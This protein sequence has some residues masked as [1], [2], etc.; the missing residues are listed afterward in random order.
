MTS[1]SLNVCLVSEEFPPDSGWGGIGTYTYN[2]ALGLSALGHRVRVISRGWG[3]DTV[4]DVNGVPVYRLSVAEPSW[5]RGTRFLSTRFYET[6]QILLWNVRVARLLRR[7]RAAEPIDLIECPE[8]HAQGV[9]AS[10][11]VTRVPVVVKLHTP[12]WLCR[13]VNGV[14]AGGSTLDTRIGEGLEYRLARRAGMLTSPSLKLAE[15][16]AKRWGLPVDA[17]RVIPNPI[18]DEL[19]QTRADVARDASRV[20]YV[21]RV[22][23]RKGVTTLADA[24]PTVRASFPETSL[25]LV[26]RD[27]PSGRDGSSMTKHLRERL[28]A[29]NV[30]ES[31]VAFT[32]PVDRAALPGEYAQAAVCVVPSLYENFPYTCLEAM[33]CGCAVVATSVGGIPEIITDG[34]DG[35]LVPPDSPQALA[36]ALALLLGDPALVRRLGDRA[37]ETIR[38]RFSRAVICAATADA[39]G[40]LLEGCQGTAFRAPTG[41]PSLAQR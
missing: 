9:L 41:R 29:G 5:R 2:L 28:A 25:R 16:V 32:G 30:P 8:Y 12:S 6:R 10:L 36:A 3:G 22:E 7:L 24:F 33:A 14:A 39:Y 13:E 31:S 20:L 17:V 18:D 19:F 27:H 34:V 26:G 11:V 23:R 21:G 35:V 40:E 15:D 1:R 4:Q 37:R 38:Q